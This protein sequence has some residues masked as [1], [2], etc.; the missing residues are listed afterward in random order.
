M[1]RFARGQDM[2]ADPALRKIHPLGKSPVLTIET[3]NRDTPLVLAES[4]LIVEYLLD[5]FGP[6]MV[7][8]R[9]PD[10][11]DRV[12]G[13]ETD[14]WLRYRYF[15]HY[16]EGSLMTPLIVTLVM[17]SGSSLLTFAYFYMTFY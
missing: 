7:P 14:A 13:G 6:Q 4:G 1:K 2:L 5:Y 16:T 11:A 8:P 12:P 15:M 9:Y 10:E 3:A 17:S